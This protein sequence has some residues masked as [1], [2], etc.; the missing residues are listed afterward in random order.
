MP[1][2]GM[3]LADIK[4]QFERENLFLPEVLTLSITEECNLRCAH[5]WV[6]AGPS[7]SAAWMPKLVVQKVIEEF[8]ALG[9]AAVRLTG[10]EPLLHPDWFEL[11]KKAGTYG[12]KVFLQT[13]GMLFRNQDLQALQALELEELN[14][15]I[16][17]DG[18][19]AATHDLVR[20]GGAFAQALAGVTNL[21]DYGFGPKI[22][23]FFTE[24]RHNLH[25]LADLLQ[26]ADRLGIGSVS[27]GS[28]VVCGRAGEV[29]L[30]APPA[31]DQ[32]LPLLRRYAEDVQFRQLY[33]KLGCVAALEWCGSKRARRGCRFVNSPYL[34]ARGVLY[35]CLLCHADEYSVADV[36]DKGLSAALLEGIPLW[37]SLQQVS[38]R[39]VLS[40]PEC[41]DCP[42]LQS[43]AGGCMG[44][45]WGSFGDF[46]VA[47]DRCQ[48]K[49]TVM[50]W[51]KNN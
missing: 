50:H 18:A 33:N 48:Q 20:G 29:G 12:L 41:Q 39:R 8:A 30:I 35:P 19:T 36:Y 4:G 16:S 43:C 26:L 3:A 47:E 23:L 22:S 1:K 10:G 28:L 34:A 11:L 44:R 25:E 2:G 49:R 32:Y 7:S 45:A 14:I 17:F 42:F 46:L 5:C 38:Q 13:N 40:I 31:P 51:K 21:I 37:S 15:Q 6:N 27:S 9:G 24:M